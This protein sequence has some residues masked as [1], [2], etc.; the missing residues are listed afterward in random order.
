MAEPLL[1]F[2]WDTAKA[3]SNERKHRISFKLA[4]TIFADPDVE[5]FADF[6]HT[7]REESWY[8]IGLCDTGAVL[9]V[10]HTFSGTGLIG[11]IR[12]ISARKATK[13]EIEVCTG[14]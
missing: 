8:S 4:T 10:V 13:T 11:S 7:G 6:D 1:L 14:S 2:G 9:I 3:E 12:I 5:T